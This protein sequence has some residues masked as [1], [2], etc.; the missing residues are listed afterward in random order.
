MALQK[1][2]VSAIIQDFKINEHDTGSTEVQVA[3]LTHGINQLNAHCIQHPKDF[4]TKRGLLRMVSQRRKLL[5]YLKNTKP[6]HYK[7][8]IEKLGLRK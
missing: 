4:S 5:A 2:T 3:L 6:E 8:T 7:K 1:E